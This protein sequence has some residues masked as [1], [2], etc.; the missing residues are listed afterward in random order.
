M[1]RK[2]L[3]LDFCHMMILLQS[4]LWLTVVYALYSLCV[5][6][7]VVKGKRET[8]V[9]KTFWVVT[10]CRLVDRDHGL[11]LGYGDS[12]FLHDRDIYLLVYTVSQPGRTSSSHISEEIPILCGEVCRH[13]PS[14]HGACKKTL[15][16]LASTQREVS[17]SEVGM[18]SNSCHH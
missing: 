11:I 10:P 4:T 3:I 5:L 16:C 13:F 12:M 6:L 14:E 17:V 2:L 18:M 15:H 9:K 8:S 1:W 7:T